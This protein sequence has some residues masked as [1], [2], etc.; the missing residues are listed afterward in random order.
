MHL[1]NH[2]QQH[3]VSNRLLAFDASRY[4]LATRHPTRRH[5]LLSNFRVGPQTL[6][7]LWVPSAQKAKRHPQKR[8]ARIATM[9]RTLRQLAHF[10]PLH[11][12]AGEVLLGSL[13]LQQQILPRHQLQATRKN[14]YSIQPRK[15]DVN[16]MLHQL[17]ATA[18]D[19]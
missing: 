15:A 11:P 4:A 7:C 10:G 17:E 3:L 13:S 2:S 8:R 9:R 18:N 19:F 12:P 1:V 5:G 16:P 14:Q 6:G